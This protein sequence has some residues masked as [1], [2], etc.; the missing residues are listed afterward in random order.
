MGY[1]YVSG[2][3]TNNI[4][5]PEYLTKHHATEVLITILMALTDKMYPDNY[6]KMNIKVN[7]NSDSTVS[8]R[9]QEIIVIILQIELF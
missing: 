4:L 6:F 7:I 3:L 5:A 1:I 9:S 8:P 2:G